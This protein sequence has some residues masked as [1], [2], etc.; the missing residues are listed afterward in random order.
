MSAFP[1]ERDLVTLP[2]HMIVALT[3]RC[4]E[5]VRMALRRQEQHILGFADS[6]ITASE[7]FAAGG[8]V[9]A[10][11]SPQLSFRTGGGTIA[12][13][14]SVLESAA[15]TL[16]ASVLATEAKQRAKAHREWALERAGYRP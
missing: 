8:T 12:P 11:V 14:L 13:A 7:H 16:R 15:R 6:V 5:R 9:P 4:A 3:G 10:Q 2:L 1:M